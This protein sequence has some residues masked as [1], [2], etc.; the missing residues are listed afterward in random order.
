MAGARSARSKTDKVALDQVPAIGL[1]LDGVALRRRR[2]WVLGKTNVNARWNTRD[3]KAAHDGISTADHNPIY[4]PRKI[5]T[6]IDLDPDDRALSDGA[7]VRTC[8]RL[9]ITVDGHRIG[10]LRQ[11]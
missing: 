8:S 7:C 9:G 1:Q 4:R 6:A 11:T 2:R 10:N 5:V 3:R